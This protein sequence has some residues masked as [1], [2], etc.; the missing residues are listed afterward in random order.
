MA[1]DGTYGPLWRIDGPLPSLRQY[2]L[3]QAADAA[4][5]EVRLVPDAD[6]DTAASAAADEWRASYERLVSAGA[7][8]S[9]ILAALQ[10]VVHSSSTVD[11]INFSAGVERWMNGVVLYPYPAGLPSVWNQC[12]ASSD[13]DVKNTGDDLGNPEFAAMVVY[14]A[15]TCTSYKVWDQAAFRDRAMLAL[16]AT[17]GAAVA[18][19][20]LTGDVL[21]LNPHLSD[22]NGT[23][24]NGDGPTSPVSALSLLEAEI[25]KSGQRGVIHTSPQMA[26]VLMSRFLAIDVQG[27]IRTRIGTVVLPDAG[28]VY[29]AS[30][31]GH[32]VATGTKEWMYATGT[33]EVRRSKPEIIPDDVKQAVD[34]GTG[35]ASDAGANSITY[36]AERYVLVDWDQQVQAAVLADRCSDTC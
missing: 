2:G 12:I 33:L 5:P 15:E 30:P 17:Y 14:L 10:G 6:M 26:T 27:V 23:F 34:R 36:R 21:P 13:G 28:Y 35:G 20:F 29:G 22:G 19:E 31:A 11:E 7:S 8:E 16:G 9:D 18:K 25:A 4:A 32:A 1:I 24:P 3:M